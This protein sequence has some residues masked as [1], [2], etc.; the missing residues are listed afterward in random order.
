LAERQLPKLEVASSSL[1]ARSLLLIL[2]V[3]CAMV[4]PSHAVVALAAT[5]AVARL[6]GFAPDRA[7]LFFVL[8]GAL[9]PDIDGEGSITKPGTMLK[10]FL[11]RFLV[12]LLDAV[13]QLINAMVKAIARHRG[14]FHWPLVAILIMA[15]GRG[16]HLHWLT[17]F[18]F[19]YLTHLVADA[20]T[21]EGV[22]LLAPYSYQ[23]YSLGLI[24][25]RSVGELAVVL[26][27]GCA[28]AYWGYPLLPEGY[29]RGFEEIRE[30][31]RRL[32]QR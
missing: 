27:L 21:P 2:F 32:H 10:H 29:L 9:M 31:Y 24:K 14:F 26:L 11:P 6:G 5:V 25:T 12:G 15:A 18:G 3:L 19:G 23:Q 30:Y 8:V 20:F 1:V 4:G 22:P 7:A 28:A 16:F 13:G 17:W